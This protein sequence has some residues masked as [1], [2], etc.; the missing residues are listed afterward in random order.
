M[1]LEIIVQGAPEV[2][3]G[4][5]FNR[6]FAKGSDGLFYSGWIQQDEGPA[7]VSN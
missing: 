6:F 7:G 5:L 3:D 2:V 1:N 4:R